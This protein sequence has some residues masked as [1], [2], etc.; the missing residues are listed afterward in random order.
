MAPVIRAGLLRAS[1]S[2]LVRHRLA[3][4]R[5]AR[6][7]VLRFMPGERL[8][9]AL[10]AARG[11]AGVGLSCVLTYLGEHVTDAADVLPAA[12]EYEHALRGLGDAGLSPHISV[13]P[14]HLG[15]G[16]DP[17]RTEALLR[18]LADRAAGAGGV[19][20]LDMEESTS[21]EATI[22][23]YRR[24]RRGSDAVGLCL[25]AYLRRTAADLAG[26]LPPGARIRLVKGAY[27]EPARLAYQGRR[28]VD[29]RFL[30][31]AVTLLRSGADTALGTHDVALLERVDRAARTIGVP[32]TAY[33]V[34]ML[35]G[36]RSPDQRRLAA[37]GYRVRVLVAY[38][39]EWFAWY[40]RRLAERP[41]N[42][43]LALRAAV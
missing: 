43:L 32:R 38:G 42:V 20:W 7:A 39:S 31:L 35:Y 30:E 14:T 10:G 26:L 34:Q 27:R 18:G 16:L 5:A 21:T 40:L 29:A 3:R 2:T 37:E 22:D 36:V 11:L 19:L 15:L 25:Q 13:K 41:A 28:D 12:A 4:S 9:D 24:L 6:R 23:L 1:E 33:E 8:E 17:R